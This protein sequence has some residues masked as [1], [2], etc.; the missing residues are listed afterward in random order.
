MHDGQWLLKCK[1]LMVLLLAGI[2]T[3]IS[4][5]ASAMPSDVSV[6]TFTG[7]IEVWLTTGDGRTKL[8]RQPDISLVLG[9]GSNSLQIQVDES[10]EYQQMDGFGA[11]LTDSSAWLISN[12]LDA[13]QTNNLMNKLFSHPIM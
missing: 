8:H 6:A 2:L 7:T 5:V 13:T 9:T 11:A 1:P 10:I 4:F 3:L 12:T